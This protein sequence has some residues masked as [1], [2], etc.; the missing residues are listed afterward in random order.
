MV[1]GLLWCNVAEA[2]I[3]FSKCSG[4]E[5]NYN[6]NSSWTVDLE[7]GTIKQKTH[8]ETSFWLINQNYGDTIVSTTPWIE[9]TDSRT[10]LL[11]SYYDAKI[12]LDLEDET[13]AVSMEP[14]F[15]APEQIKKAFKKLVEEGRMKKYVWGSCATE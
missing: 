3:T 6:Y 11:R 4:L 2:Q 1:L 7:R 8:G 15:E 13:V 5:P 12:M 14:K 9:S 10:E